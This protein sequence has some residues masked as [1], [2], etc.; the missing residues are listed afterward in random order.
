MITTKL[1]LEDFFP[2]TC[3]RAGTCCHGKTVFLNP[4]ELANIAREKKL[5]PKEFSTEYCEWGGIKLIF[6]GESTFKN[7][8]ACSQ[9]IE[10]FGCSVHLG[11]PLACIHSDEKSKTKKPIT[12]TKAYNF[13]ALQIAQR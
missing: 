7:Q 13:L 9:Y 5:S 12:Y 4:W 3:S 11:R 8:S 10:N 6:N 2:L 1:Q